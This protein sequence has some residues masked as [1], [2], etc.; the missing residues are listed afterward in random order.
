MNACCYS[1]WKKSLR[2][3][4][5]FFWVSGSLFGLEQAKTIWI[6]H[7]PGV[8]EESF[9]QTTATL[10][11]IVDTSYVVKEIGST[12][13]LYNQWEDEASLFVI[14]GGADIPYCEEL[15][16]LGN[17]KIS[18]YVECGG[19]FLG[20]CAGAYYAGNAVDF[21][22]DTELEVKGSRELSFFPG[23]VRGPF[24]APYDYRT[25][26]GS[27]AAEVFSSEAL[28]LECTSF[29]VFYNGGGTFVNAQNIENMTILAYYEDRIN[30]A[31][32]ECL[33]GKGK[34]ILSGVHFEY[35]P[36]TL[37]QQ[38]EYYCKIIPILEKKERDRIIL[39]SNLLERL[40][41]KLNIR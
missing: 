30:S 16:G 9:L 36:A 6:Y 25:N 38:D 1:L 26:S 4:L 14:P 31:I 17:Q 2:L 28:G 3:L 15:N 23:I 41:I 24:L 29:T 10:T 32:V 11:R 27:R 5:V 22:S 40:N 35:D 12:E 37:D 8:S 39:I 21:A 33:C 13:V 34:A 18:R 19:A 7:G 20:I